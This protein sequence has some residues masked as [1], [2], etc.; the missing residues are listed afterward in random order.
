MRNPAKTV[1]LAFF[2]LFASAAAS[3]EAP[4][5]P[6]LITQAQAADALGQLITT[7][8]NETAKQLDSMQRYLRATGHDK[9]FAAAHV[10]PAPAT[11]PTY[12]ELFDR[13]AAQIAIADPTNV[14]TWFAGLDDVQLFEE[15][16]ALQRYNTSHYM[17]LIALRRQADA[18]RSSLQATG[19]WPAYLRSINGVGGATTQPSFESPDQFV[20]QVGQK[21]TIDP[22]WQKSREQLRGV[23][24]A[25][26]QLAQQYQTVPPSSINSLPAYV[27]SSG[28]S[29]QWDDPRF[30]P[31]YY[32]NNNALNG[33]GDLAQHPFQFQ[34]GGGT[35]Y[36]SDTRVNHDYDM[37]LNGSYD[38]RVNID[39]DRRTNVHEDPRENF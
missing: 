9:D 32:G 5:R 25:R 3:P 38:R 8:T 13:A 19:E 39:Y 26:L 16:A 1:V 14:D 28:S 10:K 34:N 20:Q 12:S 30:Q 36:R 27:N 37:R 29:G 35:Y 7:A 2:A 15:M 21:H 17:R 18:M 4:K 31:Y 23:V 24:Q 11:Q 22:Q 33:W 6:P